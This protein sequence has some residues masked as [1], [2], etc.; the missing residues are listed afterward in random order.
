MKYLEWNNCIAA[1]LFSNQN[2]GREVFLYLTKSDIIQIGIDQ[3]IAETEVWGDFIAKVKN[4]LPGSRE[5]PTVIDK[6]VFAYTQWKRGIISIEGV[7]MT[8]PPYIM[9]LGFLILPLTEIEGAYNTNNYYDRL[10]DFLNQNNINQNCKNRL[11]DIDILWTD[12]QY[13]TSTTTNGDKGLFNVR[14]F[15][16]SKWVYVGKLFSQC[17]FPPK[18]KKKLPEFFFATGFIPGIEYS[19]NDFKKHLV[20]SGHDILQLSDTAIDLVKSHT[21]NELGQSIIE[22]VKQEYYKWNGESHIL[23]DNDLPSDTKRN[24]TLARVFIQFREDDANGKIEISFRLFSQNDF[25]DDLAFNGQTNLYGVRGWSKTIHAPYRESFEIKDEF[26]KWIGKFPKKDIRMFLKGSSFQLSAD[27]WIEADTLSRTDWTYIMFPVLLKP[28]VL[29]WASADCVNFI[30]KSDLENVPANFSLIKILKPKG[31]HPTIRQLN[32][33][34]DKTIELKSG[35]RTNF[36]TYIKTFPPVIEVKNGDGSEHLYIQYI[37]NQSRVNLEKS[38]DLENH[39]LLPKGISSD[40][41]FHVKSDTI[42]FAGNET[43]YRLISADES[44]SFLNEAKLPKRDSFG[45]VVSINTGSFVLGSNTVG[46]DILLQ[47]PYRHFF[48]NKNQDHPYAAYLP[49]IYEENRGNQLLSYLTLLSTCTAQD[50]YSAFELLLTDQLQISGDQNNINFTKLKKAALNFFDYLGYL[51]YDY[52]SGKIAVNPPQLIFIPTN[53]GR[54]AMLIGGRDEFL[55]NLL[56]EKSVELNLEIEIKKQDQS[57]EN[58]LLPDTILIKAFGPAAQNFG[59]TNIRQLAD[60]LKIKFSDAD[61]IQVGLL[62][63]SAT[64]NEYRINLLAGP[65]SENRDFEWARKIFNIQTLQYDQNTS[66]SFDTGYSLVEYKLNEYTYL[67]KLWINGNSYLVDRSW[68]KFLV[69][70]HFG[71]N[72][73]LFDQS[74]SKVAIPTALPLPRLL[75]ES[76]IL[77]SGSAP[78]YQVIDNKPYRVYRNI[79]GMFTHNLF[80]KLGQSPILINL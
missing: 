6:A 7:E 36:R 57:N 45:R 33:P 18:S 27:Y 16:N 24:Y 56:I 20:T 63:F 51:D 37:Q 67:N 58:L 4:G 47:H 43:A 55:T 21:H 26:N 15:I 34:T 23:A 30:D 1:H 75:A 79:P 25:P 32:V 54:K 8:Y 66:N 11:K 73:I 22:I 72:V 14:N 31:S 3:G 10:H 5:F 44:H 78:V 59:E 40:H 61:F 52:E 53:I 29:S 77:L 39:W 41:N 13:W 50:F 64:L 46:T 2:A 35:L 19:D 48:I 65:K 42:K 69:L 28:S 68:G 80:R 9:A 17:V 62:N 12:L 60:G 49:P 38:L 76:V 74:K 70:N 71:K